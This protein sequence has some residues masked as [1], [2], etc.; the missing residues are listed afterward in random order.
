M[1]YP[2]PPFHI[3]AHNAN[4]QAVNGCRTMKDAGT[5]AGEATEAFWS[6]IRHDG[7]RT[8]T[9][10]HARRD[11]TLESRFLFYNAAKELAL[12]ALLVRRFYLQ[13]SR[14]AETKMEVEAVVEALL[15]IEPGWG[16]Q[17]AMEYLRKASAPIAPATAGALGAAAQYVECRLQVELITSASKSAIPAHLALP[18]M[19]KSYKV[20]G[21]FQLRCEKT[22]ATL[23]ASHPDAVVNLDSDGAEFY[24]AL[25]D[26]NVHRMREHQEGAREVFQHLTLVLIVKEVMKTRRSDYKRLQNTENRAGK[27]LEGLAELLVEWAQGV[28]STAQRGGVALDAAQAL[29]VE[30]AKKI[31]GSGGEKAAQVTALLQELKAGRF[32]WA[33]SGLGE[34][35]GKDPLAVA[36]RKALDENERAREQLL[37]C[38]AEVNGVKVTSERWCRLLRAARERAEQRLVLPGVGEGTGGADEAMD[39]DKDL[40]EAAWE[41]GVA[42]A[43]A[44]R[45]AQRAAAHVKWLTAEEKRYTVMM[46]QAAKISE[47]LEAQWA[48]VRAGKT[49]EGESMK[50]VLEAALAVPDDDR[51]E[52]E[53][54][55]EEEEE[56]DEDVDEDIEEEDM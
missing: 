44:A 28:L 8:E 36:G 5:G 19:G 43:E 2:V 37:L 3:S 23:K 51:A 27:K 47:L 25:L 40:S 11:W 49:V 4:C 6:Y 56:D 22:M 17:Q 15:R 55:N 48:E 33:G 12:L 24:K 41:A 34:G 52:E 54:V 20:G 26:L 10:S 35:A 32:P 9:R 46:Q 31:I 13:L 39:V 50:E 42:A 1:G 14:M 21:T 29:A 18:G 45:A 7:A 30:E 53:E 38:L 16:V